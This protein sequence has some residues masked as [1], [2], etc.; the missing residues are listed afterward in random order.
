MSGSNFKADCLDVKSPCWSVD[1]GR[2]IQQERQGHRSPRPLTLSPI[3]EKSTLEKCAREKSALEKL[4]LQKSALEK[5]ALMKRVLEKSVLE[6]QTPEL[7]VEVGSLR[8]KPRTKPGG[9][10]SDGEWRG[11]TRPEGVQRSRVYGICCP[12]QFF[13]EEFARKIE[14]NRV[15]EN[16]QWIFN[17]IEGHGAKTER[18]FVNEDDWMLVQGSSYNPSDIRYLVIFKDTTLRT[19]RDLRQKH[20]P[21]LRRARQGVLSFL[22]SQKLKE[23]D[24]KMYFHYLPSVFQ[25]HLHVCSAASNDSIRTQHLAC[26]V[27]NIEECD[28]WYRDALILFAP[29]RAARANGMCVTGNG[30]VS[31]DK[32]TDKPGVVCI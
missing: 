11:N 27:R 20:L 16:Q 32:T 9:V 10:P 21:M 14:A 1:I 19:I 12:T 15:H 22:R 28:T 29:P 17:L 24:F 7:R 18:V 30:Y 6:K 25:L 13:C 4:V 31:D 8:R 23:D 3:L 5:S 2:A 26:V